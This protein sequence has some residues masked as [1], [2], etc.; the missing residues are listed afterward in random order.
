LETGTG[1]YQD[2]MVVLGDGSKVHIVVLDVRYDYI[3]EGN[4]RLGL[5]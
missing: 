4:D 2:Y 3:V 5:A 1:L